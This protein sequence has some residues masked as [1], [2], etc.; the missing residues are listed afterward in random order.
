MSKPKKDCMFQYIVT[1]GQIF[2][3]YKSIEDTDLITREEADALWLKYRDDFIRNLKDEWAQPEMGIWIN[4]K[5]NTDYHTSVL[6]L[7]NDT[8]YDGRRFYH[9]RVEYITEPTTK[10]TDPASEHNASQK[11]SHKN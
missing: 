1:T 6:H 5:D 7:D 4:C 8:K 3:D 10:A 9:E 11:A 2:R